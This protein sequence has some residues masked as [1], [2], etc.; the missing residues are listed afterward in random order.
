[1]KLG[2]RTW[3]RAAGTAMACTLLPLPARATPVALADAMAERYGNRPR[4]QGKVALQIP[5][6]AENGHSVA[7]AVTVASPMT[8]ADHV[9]VIDI[10]SEANPLPLIA[11]F[12]L[13]PDS[14]EASVRTRVR[15]ADSQVL[16]AV[17]ALS[18][19]SLWQ[20]TAKTIV[21]LAACTD[22]LI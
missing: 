22:F 13:S 1:M 19:G 12:T 5:A 6:L 15:L 3:L 14:G 9:Q 20:G 18:D 17:A 11:R 2:R 10:W 4:Q 8:E 21:T 7:L 16:T